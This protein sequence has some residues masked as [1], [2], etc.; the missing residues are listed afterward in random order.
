MTIRETIVRAA[1]DLGADSN[2][3]ISFSTSPALD[4]SLN[5]DLSRDS[6]YQAIVVGITDCL[7]EMKNVRVMLRQIPEWQ[8]QREKGKR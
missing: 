3:I 4:L 5:Q 8:Q 2:V 6:R 7:G 1:E